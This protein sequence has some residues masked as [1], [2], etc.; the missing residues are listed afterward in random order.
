MGIKFKRKPGPKKRLYA[1]KDCERA[2]QLYVIDDRPIE[3]VAE[4]M[5]ESIYHIRRMAEGF[6]RIQANRADAAS[7]AT[8]KESE[9]N[10]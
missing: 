5:Q 10:A 9:G 8:I 4:T 3:E 2:H 7:L 1:D 6:M